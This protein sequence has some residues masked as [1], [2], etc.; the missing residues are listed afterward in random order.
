MHLKQT[1]L[2]MCLFVK[3][4]FSI[5]VSLN[6]VGGGQSQTLDI[7][8]RKCFM[9]SLIE[10]QP[11]C[12]LI[13]IYSKTW[14]WSSGQWGRRT[15]EYLCIHIPSSSLEHTTFS[16]THTAPKSEA[17]HFHLVYLP[18]ISLKDS[19]SGPS[20]SPCFIERPRL[21]CYY[22]SVVF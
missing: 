2:K 4:L 16:S 13:L 1:L 21:V 11:I 18:H 3:C 9:I 10:S 17:Q 14:Q 5:Q 6:C 22:L 19:T 15:G 8:V 7:I 12:L 20:L